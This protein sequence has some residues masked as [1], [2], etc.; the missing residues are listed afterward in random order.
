MR[1]GAFRDDGVMAAELFDK[2]MLM[3]RSFQESRALLTAVELDLFTAVGLGAR[4]AE[5]AS[6]LGCDAR[7]TEKL[8]NALV[9]L[10]ALEK[11]DG[12]FANT[13]ETARY[14]MAGSPDD[15]R[16]A[17]MHTVHLWDRWSTLTE[18]VRRG[19]AV[20]SRGED[21][22][23]TEAFIAAMHRRALSN[24]E[25]IA[26]AVGVEGAR[27][28]LDVGGGSG[29]YS[30]AF[31]RLNPALRAEVLDLA[32]V[33]RIAQ[34]HIAEAGLGDRVTTRVGDLRRDELGAGYDLVL[35][36]AICHMLG[37]EENRDLFARCFRALAAGG[38]LVVRDFILDEDKTGPRWAALFSLNM[39]VGTERGASYSGSE[40]AEWL[41]GAGFGDVR[42]LAAD[43]DLIVARR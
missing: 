39:L 4:A 26:G 24:A 34:R 18:C 11:R 13:A 2:L 16:M 7:A 5:V 8:L 17:M 20:A 12:V 37:E 14:L 41:R 1:R 30:I 40:Y 23:W 9:S 32:D 28:M 38:R 25:Q 42:R 33:V 27:R 31:A 35:L 3:M 43:R 36:S 21:S 19:R 6:K 22:R 10:G 29:A 15:S